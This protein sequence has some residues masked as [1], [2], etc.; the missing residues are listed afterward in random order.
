MLVTQHVGRV[1]FM[2]GPCSSTSSE[3]LCVC[4][5]VYV[6]VCVFMCLCVTPR[7]LHTSA[8]SPMC[9]RLPRIRQGLFTSKLDVGG[10]H[11]LRR[12]RGG[13]LWMSAGECDVRPSAE[14]CQG[15]GYKESMEYKQGRETSWGNH[16]CTWMEGPHRT[17][18]EAFPQKGA[19]G[20]DRKTSCRNMFLQPGRP[21]GSKDPVEPVPDQG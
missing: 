15:T 5:C 10:Q 4:V 17:N 18:S 21:F 12:A 16:H 7:P 20:G 11:S 8:C 19:S 1:V 6:C 13:G 14:H 2:R 9:T 3:H